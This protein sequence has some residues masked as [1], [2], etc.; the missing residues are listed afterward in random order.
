MIKI[1]L[2]LNQWDSVLKNKTAIQTN[3]I[4]NAKRNKES[5]TLTLEITH[6]QF[7]DCFKRAFYSYHTYQALVGIQETENFPA[8]AA[9]IMAQRAV[10]HK[11]IMKELSQQAQEQYE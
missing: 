6:E 11:K 7:V 5:D 10:Y 4:Y 8:K 3:A 9:H 2:T 1:T